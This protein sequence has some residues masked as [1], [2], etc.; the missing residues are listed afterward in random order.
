MI[1]D[2]L[3]DAKTKMGKAVEVAKEDFSTVRTGRANPGMFQKVLVSYYGTP[4]PLSQLASLQ[5]QEARTLLVTPYDKGSL[6]DIEQAI[7]DMPN[8]GANPTNDG[9]LIRVTLPELTAE[10]RKEFVKIVRTKAEDAKIAVRNIRRKGKDDL[11]AMK[12]DIGD[13]ELSRGEKELE[14]LTKQHVD[15]IDEALKRKE[16]ELLEV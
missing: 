2:V 5:N 3:A 15:A 16:S 12:G 8:L 11:D 1:S 13:D 10:R 9:T 4:T 14:A 7:R 6:R